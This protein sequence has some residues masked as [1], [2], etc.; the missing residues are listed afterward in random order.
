[1]HI[2][3]NVFSPALFPEMW[4]TNNPAFLSLFW[5]KGSGKVPLWCVVVAVSDFAVRGQLSKGMHDFSEGGTLFE[6]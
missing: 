2:K 5:G 4:E 6:A 1:M 3:K